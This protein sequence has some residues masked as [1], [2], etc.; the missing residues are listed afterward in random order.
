MQSTIDGTFTPV[1]GP[2]IDGYFGWLLESKFPKNTPFG[3]VRT[4]W[5]SEGGKGDSEEVLKLSK[6]WIKYLDH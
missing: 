1:F 2:T 5:V 3:I 4:L 6:A